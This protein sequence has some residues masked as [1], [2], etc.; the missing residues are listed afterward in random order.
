MKFDYIDKNFGIR[1]IL[2][3]MPYDI[4]I[5]LCIG[6]ISFFYVFLYKFTMG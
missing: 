6:L 3:L 5:L 2:E 4:L 1:L